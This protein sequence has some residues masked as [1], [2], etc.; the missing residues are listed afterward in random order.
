MLIPDN[1]ETKLR[2]NKIRSSVIDACLTSI[3]KSVAAQMTYMT[4][5]NDVMTQTGRTAE[6]AAILESQADFPASE[7]PDLRDGLRRIRVDGLYLS[8]EELSALR[9]SLALSVSIISFFG[10]PNG[11]A[12]DATPD[13]RGNEEYPHLCQLAAE[14]TPYPLTIELIDRVLDVNGEI[15]DN[16]SPKLH[17]IRG[18]I[19]SQEVAVMRRINSIMKKAQSDGLVDADAAVSIRDGVAVIPIPASNKRALGGLVVDESATGKTAYV[20]PAEIVA[21]NTRLNELRSEE[22][23]EIIRIL[24]DVSS[25]IRPYAPD[26]IHSIEALGE[27]DFV[28]GKALY[29]KEIDA[30]LPIIDEEP[31]FYLSGARHPLLMKQLEEQGKKIVPLNIEL[32]SPSSRMLI[33]SGPNA[34]GKSVCL[35]TV[36]LLQL[37]LQSGL[38]VP[39]NEGSRMCVFQNLFIDIGD[40]QSIE[41]DLSTY[42]SHLLAMKQFVRNADGATLILIDE[43]G[44]GTEP[45]VGGAIAQAVLAELN[46]LGA[47]GVLTTH[48]TNLKHFATQTDGLVNGAMTFDT[49][50][51]EPKFS[52]LIGQPGS[53]FAF[54][55]AH[56]IGLPDKILQEAQETM[57]QENADYDRNLRQINR[58]KHYWEQKRQTVKENDKRL[59]ETLA[60]Y[61]EML[62]GIRSERKAILDKA[63]QEAQELLREANRRIENTIKEIRQKQAEKERTKELRQSLEAFKQVTE[64]VKDDEDENIVRKMEQIRQRQA[65][66]KQKVGEQAQSSPTETKQEPL[67]PPVEGDYAIIDNNPNHIGKVLSIKGGTAQVAIGNLYSSLK[68]E[69]LRRVSVNAAKKINSEKQSGIDYSNIASTVREKKL[70]F[71]SE[72]DV[73]GMRGEEALQ[74]VSQF[75]DEAI[76]CGASQVRILHGKGNGILRQMIREN[77]KGMRCVSSYR[78]ENVQF[79][80]AGITVVDL[81]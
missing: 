77:L 16:A 5:R 41:N 73:R 31:G 14:L 44:T 50:K 33:I 29:A 66:Q 46:R 6:M 52:L 53:S 43:F 9:V 30:T 40:N 25:N 19:R 2:F 32:A 34:G 18:E 60:K 54:E 4:N 42:S 49:Q 74:E 15:K 36:G 51:I 48:Y 61:N 75:I 79:G 39:V 21:I 62:D 3:G 80:G 76:L 22:R 67:A 70:T 47:F 38:L 17:D 59:S 55:I 58:D 72:I 28:R 23:R 63:K 1:I 13:H 7:L 24:K 65:R 12:E 26:M 68:I 37:M 27:I 71:K 56:K 78:D 81:K 57:G 8:E 20:Q 45:L 64:T 11:F 69:R 10:D 35:Q